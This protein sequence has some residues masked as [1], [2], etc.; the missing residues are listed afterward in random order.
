MLVFLAYNFYFSCKILQ[1]IKVKKIPCRIF[2]PFK[3]RRPGSTLP[4]SVTKS[5]TISS[6]RQDFCH[7]NFNFFF[8]VLKDKMPF[9]Y[10]PKENIIRQHKFSE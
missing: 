10:K 8:L 9:R 5:V 2:E 7:S 6:I 1:N 4:V 3:V